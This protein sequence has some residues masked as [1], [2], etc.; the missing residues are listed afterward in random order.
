MSL[1][2]VESSKR[3]L[4]IS[5]KEEERRKDSRSGKNKLKE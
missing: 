5:L 1:K 2:T 3:T 4:G